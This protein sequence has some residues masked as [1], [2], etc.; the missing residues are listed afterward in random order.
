MI[1][2]LRTGGGEDNGKSN[3]NDTPGGRCRGFPGTMKQ[4]V[5]APNIHDGRR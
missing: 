5:T 4:A 1:L 3:G 2:L